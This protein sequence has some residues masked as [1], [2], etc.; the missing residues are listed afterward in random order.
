[1]KNL[2]LFLVAVFILQI[3]AAQD[4]TSV[5]IRRNTIKLDLTSNL[6][7]RNSLNFSYERILK[8]NQSLVLIVG[9][10]EFPSIINLGENIKG[11]KKDDRGGYKFGAEYR[12]YLKKENKYS[13]PRGVYIGPY[14]TRLGFRSDRNVVYS[15][16]EEPE[17]ASLNT[18]IG[19]TSLGAQL[20]YQFVFNDRWSLDLVLIGPSYSRYNF[21]TQLS[22]DYEFSE[23]DVENEIL[24]ELINR[25]PALDD[26]LDGKELSS[27]G[28]LDTW[29]LGYKYQFLV[30]YR[31]GKYKNLTQKKH[32]N[33]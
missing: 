21:K 30:G 24:Q 13:A 9:Y 11:D 31:F 22:G 28:T 27:S 8:P 2:F 33:R 18:R 1:M 6:I 3:S 19:I 5:A 26:F 4:T 32:K 7:Y 20:G 10:Q 14:F 25:Y 29:A 12:F 15:G 17:N 23:E 16:G